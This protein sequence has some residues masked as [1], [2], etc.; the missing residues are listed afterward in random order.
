[1]G[2]GRL[3]TFS[4]GEEDFHGTKTANGDMKKPADAPVLGGRASEKEDWCLRGHKKLFPR[5]RRAEQHSD[6]RC[7]QHSNV[8]SSTAYVGA[9]ATI[10]T[11]LEI[12]TYTAM[13]VEP[14]AVAETAQKKC[15]RKQSSQSRL[16]HGTS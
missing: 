13:E 12:Y 6:S 3:V 2:L 9:D 11:R 10:D 16:V 14:W 4:R 1:M 15:T 7:F 8:F 5:P